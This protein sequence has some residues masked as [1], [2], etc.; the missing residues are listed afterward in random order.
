MTVFMMESLRS[1][2]PT[3]CIWTCWCG[4]TSDPVSWEGRWN[5]YTDAQKSEYDHIRE[6]HKGFRWPG[7][8]IAVDQLEK[9][10][11]NVLKSRRRSLK[12]ARKRGGW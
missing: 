10:H 6:K 1:E 7:S 2:I 5:A 11:K 9:D 8:K 3:F 4:E 12:R